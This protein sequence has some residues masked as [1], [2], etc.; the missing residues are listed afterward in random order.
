M[1]NVP[2]YRLTYSY[3]IVSIRHYSDLTLKLRLT[4]DQH[5]LI[6]RTSAGHCHAVNTALHTDAS[7]VCLLAN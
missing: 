3:V 4:A 6:P 1:D 5:L 7:D 2:Q